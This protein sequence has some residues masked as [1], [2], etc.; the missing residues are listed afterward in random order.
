MTLNQMHHMFSMKKICKIMR[1]IF[2]KRSM[3]FGK[4]VNNNKKKYKMFTKL[5]LKISLKNVLKSSSKKWQKSK[6]YSRIVD[7]TKSANGIL[8]LPK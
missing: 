6:F 8:N 3:K 1:S 4:K 2:K 7:L 5:S